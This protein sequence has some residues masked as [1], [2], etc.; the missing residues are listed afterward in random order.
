MTS[1]SLVAALVL[2]TMSC[3][4]DNELSLPAPP[5]GFPTA[6]ATSDCAPADG[7]AV[8]LY[9]AAEP[10]EALPPPA[11]FV[12]L[13]IWQ[14]LQSVAGKRFEWTGASSDGSARRCTAAD[15]CEQ[16]TGVL[17]RFRPLGTDSSVTGTLTLTFPGGS[18]VAGGFNAAWRPTRPL[19]G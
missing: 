11:P 6:Y 16:A 1:R 12:D 18:T 19:C 15:A 8:R 3:N 14:G 17:V 2:L 7:P 4:S 5:S 10:A 9:L 13:T